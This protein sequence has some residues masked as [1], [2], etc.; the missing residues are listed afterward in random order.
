[1]FFG[2]DEFSSKWADRNG[3][4]DDHFGPRVRRAL[5]KE[6]QQAK[7]DQKKEVKRRAEEA[8]LLAKDKKG[9]FK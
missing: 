2:K 1:M 4:R 9:W 5:H 6:N 8:R 7:D 3:M